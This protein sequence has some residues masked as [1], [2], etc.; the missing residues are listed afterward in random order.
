MRNSVFI[1]V[2]VLLA[3]FSVRA[4]EFTL[5]VNYFAG[6]K[7]KD[8]HSTEE[9]FAVT[10]MFA[11]YAI[12]YSGH[13][14]KNQHDTEKSC[15]FSDKD[16]EKIKK[17]IIEKE[18]NHSVVYSTKDSK[19][20]SFE[21]FCNIGISISMDGGSYKIALNGDLVDLKNNNDYNNALSFIA[22]LRKMFE[23]C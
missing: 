12:E 11:S 10:G 22:M 17:A 23:D 15:S 20:K 13:K 18:L 2:F 16:I 14:G 19:S 4:Q 5:T 21:E 3:A 7:S 1:S 6:E 9:N 8:S